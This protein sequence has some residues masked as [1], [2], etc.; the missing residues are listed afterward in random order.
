MKTLVWVAAAVLGFSLVFPNGIDVTAFVPSTPAVADTDATPDPRVVKALSGAESK[1]RARIVG[2]Y[3][4]LRNVITRDNASRV[5]TTE[6]W[7]ELQART[8]QM[9]IEKPG[10]YPGLDTA[11]EAVFFDA[12]QDKDTDAS[13][14]NAI[15]PEMQAKLVKACD[16]VIAST[17]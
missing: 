6:K 5:N 2:V 1:D 9:A 7:A 3:R 11:I 17:K 15:T 4:G 10:K 13:V 8:L 16:I 12:V 14:V